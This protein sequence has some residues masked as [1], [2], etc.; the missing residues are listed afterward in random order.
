MR[1]SASLPPPSLGDG[2]D[3]ASDVREAIQFA[4]AG[5]AVR[6]DERLTR[7]ERLLALSVL[8]EEARERA[9]SPLLAQAALWREIAAFVLR[10]PEPPRCPECGQRLGFERRHTVLRLAGARDSRGRR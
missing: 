6:D 1:E 5:R 9:A 8:G 10:E 3:L 7:Q 2:P 4:E